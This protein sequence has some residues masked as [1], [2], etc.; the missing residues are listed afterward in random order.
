MSFDSLL[1]DTCTIKRYTEGAADDYGRLAKTWA[2]YI[3]DEPCRLVSAKGREVSVGAKV[4]VADYVLFIDNVDVTE[5][6]RVV[7]DGDTFE[8]LMVEAK[9]N[10]SDEHHKE[11]LLK[12][13][14]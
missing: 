13:V 5:Q 1:C 8:I 14:R 10:Y 4:V 2:N 11:L 12:T 9:K 6:D 3:E 7:I